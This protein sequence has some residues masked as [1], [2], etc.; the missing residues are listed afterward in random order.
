MTLKNTPFFLVIVWQWNKKFTIVWYSGLK[1]A[2][3]KTQ[4][5]NPARNWTVKMSVIIKDMIH[6][7]LYFFNNFTMSKIFRKNMTC[8]ISVN[9]QN[10]PVE[11][12]SDTLHLHFLWYISFTKKIQKF[13]SKHDTM[14]WNERPH[15]KKLL[16]VISN[17]N[18]IIN[19]LQGL[20]RNLQQ[21]KK[22]VAFC[23]PYKCTLLE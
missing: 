2:I 16:H 19:T 15:L 1:S 20:L 21:N 22:W 6:I 10:C 11:D 9:F 4:I 23:G 18:R 14:E 17:Q 7:K 13:K 8:K 3:H 12:N 5:K